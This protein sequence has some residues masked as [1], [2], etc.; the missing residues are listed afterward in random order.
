MNAPISLVPR[1]QSTWATLR[2]SILASSLILAG[3]GCLG[4][5]SYVDPQFR[6]ATYQS[7]KPMEAPKLVTITVE[8]QVN[9]KPN[10]QQQVVVRRKVV[11]VLTATRV[12]V[13]AKGPSTEPPAEL[14]VVVNNV[15][16]I[17]AAVG[18]GFAT[19]L[20]F[21]LA[22]SHVVDGYELTATYTPVNGNPVI[23]TYKHAIHSTIGAH[24]APKGMEPVPLVDAFD[25]VVEE[26]LLNF[27]R[28]LQAQHDLHFTSLN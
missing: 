10:K 28:D 5:K 18:K 22:G 20:T 1:V 9:G 7:I 13:E 19:G 12:F 17:G 23:R 11:R 2:V 3:T 4:V 21:G 16:D 26:M 8:F 14:R 24:S 6:D 27:L 15:G 25:Q